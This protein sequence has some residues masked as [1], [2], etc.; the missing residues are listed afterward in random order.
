MKWN[1][2]FLLVCNQID[3]DRK[4]TKGGIKRSLLGL[5]SKEE[6]AEPSRLTLVVALVTPNQCP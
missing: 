5:H 4:I 1:T 6:D 2:V 3:A